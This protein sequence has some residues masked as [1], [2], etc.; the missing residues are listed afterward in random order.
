MK[1]QK[2]GNSL[3]IRLPKALCQAINIEEGKE[4]DFT[5]QE[6]AIVIKPKAKTLEEMLEGITPDMY[7]K[8]MLNDRA[9]GKEEW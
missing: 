9:V 3:A 4:V 8:E 6:N 2:W 1:V 5:I 7:H